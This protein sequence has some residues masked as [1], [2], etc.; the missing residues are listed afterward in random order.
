MKCAAITH[1]A[2][3]LVVCLSPR[4]QTQSTLATTAMWQRCR[5]AGVSAVL[6]NSVNRQMHVVS[7]LGTLRS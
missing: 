7:P 2:R 1:E 4:T 6:V 5:R 3:V